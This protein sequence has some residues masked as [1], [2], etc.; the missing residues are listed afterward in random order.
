MVLEKMLEVVGDD[1]K[2]KDMK[3]MIRARVL[4]IVVEFSLR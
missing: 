2:N 3:T 1:R 4:A